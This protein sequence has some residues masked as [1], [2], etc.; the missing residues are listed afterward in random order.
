MPQQGHHRYQQYQTA[1]PYDSAPYKQGRYRPQYEENPPLSP[2]QQ[3]PTPNYRGGKHQPTGH[4]RAPPPP[5]HMPVHDPYYAYEPHYA[6]EFEQMR[7][8][9][10]Q[11]PVYYQ[12]VYGVPRYMRPVIYEVRPDYPPL[13]RPELVPH[14]DPMSEPFRPQVNN[15][16][17]ERRLYELNNRQFQH[18]PYKSE[19]EIQGGKKRNS[20]LNK[21]PGGPKYG[22]QQDIRHTEYSEKNENLSVNGGN[23][24]KQHSRRSIDITEENNVD[25]DDEE[26]S[27]K[28][29]CLD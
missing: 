9:S 29:A 15:F 4:Y 10:T 13:Y 8:I 14:H 24:K 19:M 22:S 26:G 2:F 25:G 6:E 20:K 16:H 17:S 12:P 21:Y 23:K 28:K 18:A 11:P 27:L 5:H 7:Y 1:D 3:P